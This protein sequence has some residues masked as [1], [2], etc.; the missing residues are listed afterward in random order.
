MAD[1]EVSELTQAAALDGTELAHVVQGGNSRR[2]SILAIKDGAGARVDVA[3]ATT[4]NIGAAASQY[5]RIT[6]TTT[7][8]AFDDVPAGVTRELLFDASL[9]IDHD[10]TGLINLT[11]DDIVTSPGDMAIFRSEGSGNWRM[12]SYERANGLALASSG[13]QLISVQ[14]VSSAVAAVDFTSG[15]DAT[16]DEYEITMHGVLPS[17]NDAGLVLRVSTDGGATYQSSSYQAV[18][19]VVST[20]S[21]NTVGSTTDFINVSNVLGT[22]GVRNTATDGGLSGSMQFTPNG[23]SGKTIF[24]GETAYLSAGAGFMRIAFSGMWNGGNDPV[25]ALRFFFNS[26][27]IAAGTFRL[28]GRRKEI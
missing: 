10:A 4:T 12:T 22:A 16:Y 9:T 5:V 7:I 17:V 21:A 23:S 15:I 14:T 8:E 27:N 3:S 20:A 1:K 24:R 18:R 19:H 28:W 2:T 11:G 13:L 25:D 6:G 26:G